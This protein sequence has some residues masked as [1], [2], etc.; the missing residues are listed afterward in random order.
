LDK[1]SSQNHD[2][3]SKQYV[4]YGLNSFFKCHQ[5]GAKSQFHKI[6][7]DPDSILSENYGRNGFVKSAPGNACDEETAGD[8]VG[9]LSRD[10]QDGREVGVG[11]RDARLRA[12]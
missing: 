7:F 5:E 3:F 11:R 12:S 8:Q 4:I 10:V 2:K 9:L 6:S 1:I